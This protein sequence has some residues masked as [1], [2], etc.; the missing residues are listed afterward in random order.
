MAGVD[1]NGNGTDCGNSFLQL[2]LVTTWDVN[3]ASVSSARCT[4]LVLTF[5]TLSQNTGV[6]KCVLG[7][8]GTSTQRGQTSN[9]TAATVTLRDPNHQHNIICSC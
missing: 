6:L 5:L 8:L 3:V 4:W 9:K 7:E 2:G 1:S